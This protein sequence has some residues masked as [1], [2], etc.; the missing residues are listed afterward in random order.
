MLRLYWR[1]GHTILGR[2]RVE[3][4]GSGVLN[5]LA[6]DL[7]AEFPSTEGFSLANLAYMRRYAEGWMEDAI[8]QQAVGEL[9]WSHIVSLLDKL[10]DQSLRDWYAAMHV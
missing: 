10:D 5:R 4:W 3:S 6:A 9:P 1:I 8:L 2:Q 7:R